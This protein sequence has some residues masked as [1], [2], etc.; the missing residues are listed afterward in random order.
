MYIPE[1]FGEDRVEVLQRAIREAGLAT[2]ISLTNDGLIASHIP[3]LVDPEPAPYGTLYGHLARPNPQAQG[4]VG[5]ALAIFLGPDSYITPSWY[6]TKQETGKVVPTWN[7]V[8]VHAYGPLEFIDDPEHT[9]QH[10]AQ[11]TDRHE[12]GRPTPWTTTDAPG[13]FIAALMRGIIAFRL[14]VRRLEGKWKMSQNRPLADRL[15]VAHGLEAEGK[16]D[17]AAFVRPTR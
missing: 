4:A 7:Y 9:R 1:P 12:T 5:D 10:I 14:T 3:L 11:L 13:E 15:G 2:L 17:L 6:P 16:P 8:A